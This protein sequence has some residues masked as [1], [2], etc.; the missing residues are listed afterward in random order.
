MS[1][2]HPICRSTVVKILKDNGFDPGPKRGDDSWD[3]FL[4]CYA[5]TLWA[6]DFFSSKFWT[7]SGLVGVFVLFFIHLGSR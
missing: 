7:M 5:E 2:W 6:C 3:Q 4:K 1:S